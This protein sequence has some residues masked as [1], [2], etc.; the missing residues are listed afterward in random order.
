M[1]HTRP[2]VKRLVAFEV[3][4]NPHYRKD[5][6]F[7][8]ANVLHGVLLH[9]SLVESRLDEICDTTIIQHIKANVSPH[10]QL[11]KKIER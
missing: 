10:F 6:L 5:T 4:S 9:E 3:L 1:C 8:I 2:P 7:E 11:Y